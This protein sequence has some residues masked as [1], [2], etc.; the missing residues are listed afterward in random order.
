MTNPKANEAVRRYIDQDL[1]R[2]FNVKDLQ[3]MAL[4]GAEQQRAKSLNTLLGPKENPRVDFVI[5]SRRYGS[6]QR[7]GA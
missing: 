6:A 7:A 5:D 4:Q 3:N 2:Q 1:N